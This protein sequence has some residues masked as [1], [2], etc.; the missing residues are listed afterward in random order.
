[1]S[2]ALIDLNESGPCRTRSCSNRGKRARGARDI[3]DTAKKTGVIDKSYY[4]EACLTAAAL[5]SRM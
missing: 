2:N 4:C 3:E 1:M 5:R